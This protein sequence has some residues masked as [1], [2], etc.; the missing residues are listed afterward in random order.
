MLL[1]LCSCEPSVLLYIYIDL[2]ILFLLSSNIVLWFVLSFV[3]A[4]HVDPFL[5]NIIT[6]STFTVKESPI[7][8]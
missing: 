3:G 2:Y 4:S 5:Y 8:T 6:S 1:L 7:L